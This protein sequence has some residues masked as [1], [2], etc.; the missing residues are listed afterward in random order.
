M[1]INIFILLLLLVLSFNF[2]ESIK[3]LTY[4]IFIITHVIFREAYKRIDFQIY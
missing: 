4:E 3:F 2:I 1:F